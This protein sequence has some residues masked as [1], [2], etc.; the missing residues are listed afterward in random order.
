MHLKLHHA[1]RVT[2]AFIYV[3][4]AL[5][6]VAA[7]LHIA[8]VPLAKKWFDDWARE[9]GYT[10][11]SVESL[12][13]SPLTGTAA[14]GGLTLAAEGKTVLQVREAGIDVSLVD[15]LLHGKLRIRELALYGARVVAE[16]E[17]TGAVRIAG[18]ELKKGR[19]G[20]TAVDISH[21]HIS[22][23][24]IDFSGPHLMTVFHVND[25]NIRDGTNVTV[26]VASFRDL[27]L[28]IDRDD[29][30]SWRMASDSTALRT[31]LAAAGEGPLPSDWSLRINRI[32]VLGDS[33]IN[34][35]DSVFEKAFETRVRVEE[36]RIENIDS[37]SPE[38]PATFVLRS[39]TMNR[40][41]LTIQGTWF[42][43]KRP[44]ELSLTIDTRA[45]ALPVLADLAESQLGLKVQSQAV[46]G[47]AT[48][49]LK[50]GRATGEIELSLTGTRATRKDKTMLELKHGKV[51]LP[52][53]DLLRGA[54]RIKLAHFEGARLNVERDAA[55]N[56]KLAGLSRDAGGAQTG[57]AYRVDVLELVD[58]ELDLFG[59]TVEV[60]LHVDELR[61][62]QNKLIRANVLSLRDLRLNVL[63]D[64]Q[65]RWR[66]IGES[67]GWRTTAAPS[68]TKKQATGP[69][70]YTWPRVQIARI[71]LV[72]DSSVDFEEVNRAGAYRRTLKIRDAFITGIDSGAPEQPVAFRL[73]GVT[74]RHEEL[75]L[76]GKLHPFKAGGEWNF[77]GRLQAWELT[78]LS[79]FAA[80]NWGFHIDSGQGDGELNLAVKGDKISGSLDLRLNLFMVTTANRAK[81]R[82]FEKK[83]P[84]RLQTIVYVL[85][86]KNGTIGL[87]VPISGDKSDPSL[88]LDIDISGAINKAMSGVAIV[89]LALAA[90]GLAVL[91]E[92]LKHK[93][94]PVTPVEFA[95]LS[96]ELDDKA[97][98]HLAEVAKT[99]ESHPKA[100][101][102]ICGKAT[103]RD[104]DARDDDDIDVLSI[105]QTRA[106]TVKDYLIAQHGMEARRLVAC[107]PELDRPDR[108]E[109]Y[110][111]EAVDYGDRPVPRVELR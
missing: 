85:T 93:R 103:N 109:S 66:V 31:D 57:P 45:Q 100:L 7:V 20:S 33:T 92:S 5:V 3:L 89:G 99:L 86:D 69:G 78:P 38:S 21:L 53:A 91:L 56:I 59:P 97:R 28:N 72:G 73:N 54:M 47:H 24:E 64:A 50:D 22:D 37:T 51:V 9:H 111:H 49:Q 36:A 6:I 62:T 11:A 2:R 14:I 19:R 61:F 10:T 79:P 39:T 74:G 90:P 71:E 58:S 26:D 4:A 101:L 82:A 67:G 8:V 46:D 65:Q 98:K 80:Q 18:I 106:D 48:V 44:L 88:G 29:V 30:T 15:L 52:V 55:G 13:V 40:Q 104:L 1:G 16:R 68:D 27:Q 41:A 76:E 34:Y 94:L 42:P 84:A 12:W 75:A 23:S 102:P 35:R 108:S 70:E 107:R 43:F 77:T 32:Q 110:G 81:L 60:V 63:Q 96:I 25:L 83:L 87:K 95:P 17:K 105:A